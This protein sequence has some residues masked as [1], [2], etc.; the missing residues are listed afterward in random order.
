MGPQH[1]VVIPEALGKIELRLEVD[2]AIAAAASPHIPWIRAV[3][4]GITAAALPVFVCLYQCE[5]SC[6][7]DGPKE[8]SDGLHDGER[9]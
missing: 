8:E 1:P 4:V 7:Q 3:T 6:R 2:A 5:V 9:V